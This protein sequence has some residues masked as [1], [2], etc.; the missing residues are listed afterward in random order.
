MSRNIS[1]LRSKVIETEEVSN[2]KKSNCNKKLL[3]RTCGMLHSVW[4]YLAETRLL[5]WG[6]NF[7]E[8]GVARM[9]KWNFR[10]TLFRNPCANRAF[11]CFPSVYSISR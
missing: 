3:H 4:I 11:N 9:V 5:S 2:D 6:Y 8:F 7:D 1:V 10:Y